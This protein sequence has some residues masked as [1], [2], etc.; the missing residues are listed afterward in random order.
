MQRLSALYMVLFLL[1]FSLTWCGETI[2]YAAWKTW[3]IHPVVNVALILFV[4]SL[5][6]HAWIGIRDVIIDY[7]KADV[8]RYVLLIAIALILLGL[9]LWAL[10]ILLLLS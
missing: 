1:G 6:L 3:A 7:V 5:L 4:I 10:K 9:T 2:E 8:V